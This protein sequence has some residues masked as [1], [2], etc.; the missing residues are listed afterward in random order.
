MASS[1]ALRRRLRRE[2]AMNVQ[3]P[4]TTNSS[5]RRSRAVG[6]AAAAVAGAVVLTLTTSVTLGCHGGAKDH[7]GGD[8]LPSWPSDPNWQ[9]LVL[10]P[11]RD[12]VTPVAIA[13]AHGN[14]INPE[15]LVSRSGT[16][17]L[18]VAPGGPPAV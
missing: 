4:F 3:G 13:R 5:P 14:V 10:G 1:R 15:A 12:D 6:A 16:T 11:H 9:R 18:T 17:T 2:T 8:A 7:P